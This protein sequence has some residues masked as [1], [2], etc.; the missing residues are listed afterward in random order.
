[1]STDKKVSKIGQSI[2]NL[3]NPLQELLDTIP[4]TRNAVQKATSEDTRDHVKR[5][6]VGLRIL[7]DQ[8]CRSCWFQ[9]HGQIISTANK[10]Q[11]PNLTQ[12]L[13]NQ[14]EDLDNQLAKYGEDPELAWTEPRTILI[15]QWFEVAVARVE[16]VSA[17]F[18]AM[19]EA[20]DY[21]I[22]EPWKAPE[23][24][25]LART[26]SAPKE[27]TVEAKAAALQAMKAHEKRQ[28][29]ASSYLS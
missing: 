7:L 6:D 19:K 11:V 2:I 28:K 5:Q 14:Q 25:G 29:T 13:R 17:L 12:R 22:G 18:T 9:L 24:G 15:N 1:M 26:A 20:Y 23:N 16:S 27:V 21:F 8:M 10:A 3:F 4:D